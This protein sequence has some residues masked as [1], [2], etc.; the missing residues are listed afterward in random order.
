[1]KQSCTSAEAERVGRLT[2]LPVLLSAVLPYAQPDGKALDAFLHSVV[3]DG[4]QNDDN[5]MWAVQHVQ[6]GLTLS[7]L[8]FA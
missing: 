1:M 7:A 3:E 6:V 8:A 2:V 5:T 4:V